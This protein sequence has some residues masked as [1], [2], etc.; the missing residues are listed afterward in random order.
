[1]LNKSNSGISLTYCQCSFREITEAN[2][3]FIKYSIDA[4]PDPETPFL[5]ATDPI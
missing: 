5:P 1:M 2:L 4:L 3:K